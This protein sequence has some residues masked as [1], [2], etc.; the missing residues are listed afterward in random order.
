MPNQKWSTETGRE[1]CLWFGHTHL[2]AGDFRSVA[3]DEM[4]HRVGWRKRADRGQH[5]KCI[6]S[7]KDHI[8]RMSGDARNLCVLD[9]LDR[10]RATRV[11]RDAR[12]RVIDVM[13]FIEND[14]L[15]HRAEAQRLK[16]IR[17]AFRR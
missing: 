16:N 14:I 17:L 10:I 2:G 8:S 7:E 4:I 13:I 12:V 1:R 6:A 3:A 5:T 15:Q 11:L 9:E